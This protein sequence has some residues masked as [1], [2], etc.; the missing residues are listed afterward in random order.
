MIVDCWYR[1]GKI[2]TIFFKI[3]FNICQNTDIALV[4]R[5]LFEYFF[6]EKTEL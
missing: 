1:I 6:L 3:D 2:S 4:Q 5:N